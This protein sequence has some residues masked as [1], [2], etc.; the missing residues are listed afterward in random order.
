MRNRTSFRHHLRTY[1]IHS[2]ASAE[3]SV[4]G[5]IDSLDVS[6]CDPEPCQLKHN[7]NTTVTIKLTTNEQV[8]AGKTVVY[9]IIDGLP[10]PFPIHPNDACKNMPCPVSTG[11]T[12]TYQ[13]K[14]FIL[15]SYPKIKLVVKWEIQD[16]NGKDIIC[17]A[18][19]AIIVD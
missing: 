9:G 19:P 12:V 18:I 5:K 8:T 4:V 10:V 2:P 7:T 16:Q 1:S 13:N 14:I 11:A 6:S 15:P 17:F 3:S